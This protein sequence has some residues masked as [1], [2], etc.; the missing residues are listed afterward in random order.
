MGF[1]WN[2]VHSEFVGQFKLSF[3]K[4]NEKYTIKLPHVYCTGIFMG[5]RNIEI[6]DFLTI[7]CAA[8]NCEASV[9]FKGNAL[10]G[11]VSKGKKV[12]YT[13]E[14]APEK[15]V[16]VKDVEE[17]KEWVAYESSKIKREPII[18]EK[19]EKQKK[20]NQESKKLKI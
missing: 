19:L 9:E 14:G 13:L 10:T 15:L 20:M 4:L 7:T 5:E 18:V 11:K 16:K 6:W 1:H 3:F 17:K 2:S 12:F 8:T